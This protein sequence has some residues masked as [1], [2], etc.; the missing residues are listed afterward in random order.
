M[1]LIEQMHKD[2]E[3]SDEEFQLATACVEKLAEILGKVP[4]KGKLTQ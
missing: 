3:L 2:G 1:R 4:G